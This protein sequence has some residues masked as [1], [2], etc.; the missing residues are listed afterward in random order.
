MSHYMYW[1][2]RDW[3]II[4]RKPNM[5]WS[6]LCESMHAGMWRRRGASVSFLVPVSKDV[7][8]VTVTLEKSFSGE[9]V[10]IDSCMTLLAT[11]WKNVSILVVYRSVAHMQTLGQFCIVVYATTTV[12]ISP[13]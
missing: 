4:I 8:V 5:S 6:P 11:I 10:P 9:F 13:P 7:I 1:D 3:L 2:W 12:V